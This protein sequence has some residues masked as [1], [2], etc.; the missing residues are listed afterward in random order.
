MQ[1]EIY[2]TVSG[3]FMLLAGAHLLQQHM[4]WRAL[5]RKKRINW[6]TLLP[7][8][9]FFIFWCGVGIILGSRV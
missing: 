1:L 6:N 8:I 2:R 4:I 7:K 9:A 3:I 5:A